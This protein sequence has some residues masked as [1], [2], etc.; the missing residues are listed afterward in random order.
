MVVGGGHV[1]WELSMAKNLGF[2]VFGRMKLLC[3]ASPRPPSTLYSYGVRSTALCTLCTNYIILSSIFCMSF[4]VLILLDWAIVV[5]RTGACVSKK[6]FSGVLHTVQIYT[7][8][9]IYLAMN[10][11]VCSFVALFSSRRIQPGK[12]EQKC[13]HLMQVLLYRHIASVLC[14][15]SYKCR[16]TLRTGIL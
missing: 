7:N 14:E 3:G 5:A 11:Q 1:L 9:Y 16:N 13:I 6:Y 4:I 8:V 15:T 10:T 12:Q 2:D